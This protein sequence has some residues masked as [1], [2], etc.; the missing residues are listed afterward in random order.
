MIRAYIGL[1]GAGKTLAMV[2]DAADIMIKKKKRVISNVP[3]KFRNWRKDYE[4]EFYQ[5][6]EF[7]DQILKAKNTLVLIDEASLVFP[8]YF[9]N[10]IPGEFLMKFAQSRKYAVDIFYTSQ[11]FNHSVKRLRD[12]TNEVVRCEKRKVLGLEVFSII[13]YNPEYFEQKIIPSVEIE[14]RYIIKRRII[15][16]SHAK[17]LFKIYD[18]LFI[19][20]SS[21]LIDVDISKLND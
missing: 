10:K 18:T 20:D 17:W 8:S 1:L 2:N 19:V 21:A 5:G 15:S 13:T 16:P 7:Q 6:Q 12:I 9:W 4:A 3:I 14:K 11:G